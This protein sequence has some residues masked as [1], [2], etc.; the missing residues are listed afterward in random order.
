METQIQPGTHVLFQDGDSNLPEA[1]LDR[2]GQV[3]LRLCKICRKGEIE[4]DQPCAVNQS[5]TATAE[6][7]G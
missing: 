6:F 7:A 4:L 5:T 2:N 3:A 1:I